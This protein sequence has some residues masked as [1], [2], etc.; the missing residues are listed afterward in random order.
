MSQEEEMLAVNN[1]RL[2]KEVK[3][4]RLSLWDQF[5]MSAIGGCLHHGAV[6]GTK[7]AAEVADQ[8]MTEREARKKCN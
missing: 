1:R 3:A 2:E 4:L 8:M 5:F 6:T 7:M